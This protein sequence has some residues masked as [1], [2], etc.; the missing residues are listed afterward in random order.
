MKLGFLTVIQAR[1]FPTSEL[2]F[3][4]NSDDLLSIILMGRLLI[5]GT[6]ATFVLNIFGLEH[7][8]LKPY[9]DGFSE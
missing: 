7:N 2:V 8:H 9:T 5:I 3:T 6:I 1:D 4:K